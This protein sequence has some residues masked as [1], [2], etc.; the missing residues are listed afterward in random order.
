MRMGEQTLRKGVKSW[1][2]WKK[3]EVISGS[4]LMRA[5]SKSKNM[6]R[7]CIP[8][9]ETT[10]EKALIAMKEAEPWADL[11]ELRADYLKQV[12]LAPFLESR[13]KPLIVTHRRN[14]EGGKYQGEERKRLSLLRDAIDLGTDY[15]DVELASERSFVQGLI[16]NKR[17]TQV[18]LS[19][20]DFRRTPSHKELQRLFDRMVR[21]RADVVKIVSFARSWEDNLTIL[22]LIP[23]AKARK[24]KIVAF[25]MGEKGK[26]SRF[27]SPRLGAA[28]TYAS[29]NKNKTSA[30]GQWTVG[31]L[32]DIGEEMG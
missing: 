24:Q 26:V 20:H 21:L 13:Q 6:G 12:K 16:K 7:I 19:F 1:S 30:P 9:I 3:E 18:I 8:I 32:R 5:S 11:I 15:I 22:S 25:C 29:L 14:E 27:F 31:E 28:W 2:A 23:F 4:R 10:V 17:G